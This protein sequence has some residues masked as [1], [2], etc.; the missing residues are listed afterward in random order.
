MTTPRA[1][2]GA[3][4]LA[5]GKSSRFGSDKASALLR[6]RPLLEWVARAAADVCESTV[7]V[8]AKGQELP[9]LDLAVPPRVVEDEQHGIGPLAGIIAGM[10]ASTAERCLV[11]SCDAPLLQPRLIA[12]LDEYLAAGG[13]DIVLP[14]ANGHPQPLLAIYRRDAALPVFKAALEAGDLKINRII[15]SLVTVRVEEPSLVAA[16][17][18]LDSFRNCNTPGALAELE[19]SLVRA[20]DGAPG[21]D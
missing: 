8:R 1:G 18:A 9:S 21:N 19:A 5:G 15:A 10:R 12:F 17:P 13:A 14:I 6:G 16:D 7:V 4:I 11:C 2:L 3:I 20:V